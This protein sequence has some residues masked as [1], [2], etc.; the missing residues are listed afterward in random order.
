MKI[1]LIFSVFLT[2]LNL[3]A[4]DKEKDIANRTWDKLSY[5]GK[6]LT[7]GELFRPLSGEEIRR[8]SQNQLVLTAAAYF[9]SAQ[10]A[11]RKYAAAVRTSWCCA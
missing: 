11:E 6:T 5:D 3:A 1:F 10:R 9:L 8:R 4:Q 7:A 2:L